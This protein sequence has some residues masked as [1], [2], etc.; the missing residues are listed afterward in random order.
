MT[1]VPFKLQVT[2]IHEVQIEVESFQLSLGACG[3][4]E[5]NSKRACLSEFKSATIKLKRDSMELRRTSATIENCNFMGAC[6]FCL[7]QV[8]VPISDLNCASSFPGL[9]LEITANC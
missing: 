4:V 6:L 8:I 9:A 3:T 7:R 5:A 2:P 1:R